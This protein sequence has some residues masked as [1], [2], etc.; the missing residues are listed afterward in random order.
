MI[1][2]NNEDEIEIIADV[3]NDGASAYQ[4]VVPAD[5]LGDPYMSRRHLA[6]EIAAGVQFWVYEDGGEILGVM[7]IQ[8]IEDV[9]LIRHAYVRTAGRRRGIGGALLAFLQDRTA[10]PLLIGTWAAAG[11][12]LDFYQKHGFQLIAGA[13]KD[14]LLAAY[15]TVPKRQAKQS[16]VLADARW[17]ARPD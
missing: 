16:V 7:G 8:D 5:G 17:F 3:I 12:A 13:D 9:T 4:G 11:W 15:W 10:R 1:R 2:R 6:D 14:A